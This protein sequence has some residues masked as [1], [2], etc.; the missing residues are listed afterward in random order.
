MLRT[1]LIV[2]SAA[3]DPT[4]DPTVVSEPGL[5]KFDVNLV[6]IR[7]EKLQNFSAI[8]DERRGAQANFRIWSY[9]SS[10]STAALRFDRR[11]TD[12]EFKKIL[13]LIFRYEILELMF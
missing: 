13:F 2:V 10:L 7:I 3:I 12:E 11:D 6:L 9:S 5:L 8:S 1:W 4:C